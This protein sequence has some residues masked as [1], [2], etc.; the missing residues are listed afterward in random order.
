MIEYNI[1]NDLTGELSAVIHLEEGNTYAKRLS[2]NAPILFGLELFGWNDNPTE[3]QIIS[4]LKDRVMPENRQNL[5]VFLASVG[6]QEYDVHKM[7]EINHGRVTDDYFSL[8]R[9]I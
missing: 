9:V 4:F 2:D 1:I 8:K 5:H 3:E 7:I 6:L